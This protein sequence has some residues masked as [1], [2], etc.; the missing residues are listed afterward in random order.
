MLFFL[1]FHLLLIAATYDGNI[2]NL[3][4]PIEKLRR[5]REKQ[6]RKK[7]KNW[8]LQRWLM[9]LVVIMM[10]LVAAVAASVGW[11]CSSTAISSATDA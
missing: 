1:H 11:Q 7:G 3:A 9:M 2:V 8:Q 4:M 10:M 5:R 6:Q